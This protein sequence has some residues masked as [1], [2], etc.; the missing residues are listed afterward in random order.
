MHIPERSRNVKINSGREIN[1][2]FND[3][4]G[5]VINNG[6]RAVIKMI[7]I[8]IMLK[9]IIRYLNFNIYSPMITY[10][11]KMILRQQYGYWGD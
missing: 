2:K 7:I 4:S 8:I 11:R 3:D 6:S 5:L 1:R 9:K 10:R